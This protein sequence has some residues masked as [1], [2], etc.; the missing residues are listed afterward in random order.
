MLTCPGSKDHNRLI[1]KMCFY[2]K[3]HKNI[4][5]FTGE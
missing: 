4:N 1:C 3:V 2:V 5:C